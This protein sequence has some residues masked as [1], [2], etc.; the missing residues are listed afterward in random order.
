[1][2]NGD[3]LHVILRDFT[4]DG[5][6]ITLNN[7]STDTIEDASII[8]SEDAIYNLIDKDGNLYTVVTIGNQQWTVQNLRT[9]TYADGTVI[10]EIQNAVAWAADETGAHC[11]YDN[12]SATYKATYGT[13]Y[14]WYAM[15]SSHGLVYFERGG[16]PATGWRVP[17][18]T[19][20]NIL[21][22]YILSS[23]GEL[24]WLTAGGHLK[25]T[26]DTHWTSDDGF[27]YDTFGFTALGG[28][29]RASTGVFTNFNDEARI[30]SITGYKEA[31]GSVWGYCGRMYAAD[32]RF[33]LM[34]SQ[35]AVGYSIRCVRDIVADILRDIDGNEYTTVIIG[36]Q[37]WR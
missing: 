26:G 6:T 25:E 10:P 36:S 13:L 27:T 23:Q 17:T 29:F 7:G 28:G 1:M 11:Y 34:L 30:G 8:E 4:G 33:Q 31:L 37:E 22:E 35:R 32:P 19:D 21:L 9:E 12:D 15:V 16:I 14:N 3:V 20:L 5:I 2:D 24:N 18:Y